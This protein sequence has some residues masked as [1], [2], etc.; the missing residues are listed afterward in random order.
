MPQKTIKTVRWMSVLLLGMCVQF[1]T[2]LEG[3]NRSLATQ[4]GSGNAMSD[5]DL[6]GGLVGVWNAPTE[7]T[8]R[9][10]PLDVE[11]FGPGASDVRDVKL[12]IEPSGQG[13]LQVAMA[14]VDARGHRL[15]PSI[16]AAK[17]RIGAPQTLAPGGTRPTITIVSAEERFLE[18]SGELNPLEGIR[19]TMTLP[20]PAS[21]TLLLRFDTKDGPGSFGT[22]LQR[23]AAP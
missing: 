14:V 7:K 2:S 22:T 10:S 12:T 11:V 20:S 21:E 9:G 17:F 5:A 18:G 8:E 1:A 16:V 4:S 15:V 23:R 6:L 3:A 19:V 13:D